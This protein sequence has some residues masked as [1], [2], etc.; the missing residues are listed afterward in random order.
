M[1]QPTKRERPVRA[2]DGRLPTPL[3]HQI[4]LVLRAKILDGTFGEDGRLPSEQELVRSFGVSR[5]TAKR[6]LDELAAEGLVV[7]E[8]GRGTRLRGPVPQAPVKAS[9]E[10]LMENVLS[11]GLKTTVEHLVFEERPATEDV[12]G[13]LDLPVGKP[14]QFAARVRRLGDE[15]IAYVETFV[16][17]DIGRLYTKEELGQMPLLPLLESKGV[18][19]SRA[20]Q[21]I[22]AALAD[23]EMARLL[24]IEVGA[25]LLRVARVVF[26]VDGRAVEQVTAYYRPDLY[27]YRMTL[28]RVPGEQANVWA[29]AA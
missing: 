28:S 27:Q 7:R 9:V 12:A 16:P 5:I 24:D 6:S 2:V 26:N 10:G 8:R 1:D 17:Q 3:Y 13:A 19:V 15:P 22:T 25:A 23:G 29:P 20:D 21:T 11:M 14:V 18:E 4:Y